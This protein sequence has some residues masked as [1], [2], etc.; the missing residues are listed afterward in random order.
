LLKTAALLSSAQSNQNLYLKL[1]QNLPDVPTMACLKKMSRS[2]PSALL[3]LPSQPGYQN[4]PLTPC[5]WDREGPQPLLPLRLEEGLEGE[6][7]AG[8]ARRA[9]GPQ[10]VSSCSSV[11]CRAPLQAV[12]S[13]TSQPDKV[14]GSRHGQACTPT[15]SL[16][17]FCLHKPLLFSTP[18][19]SSASFKQGCHSTLT[20]HSSLTGVRRASCLM[21]DSPPPPVGLR[22][23]ALGLSAVGPLQAFL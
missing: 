11:P 1:S 15:F 3:G 6:E 19:P 14:W 21:W 7:G 9:Q 17:S 10:A 12:L 13:P 16:P 8:G 18:P 4:R 2:S 23:A 22:P 20:P 5:P